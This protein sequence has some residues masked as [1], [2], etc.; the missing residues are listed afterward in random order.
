MFG[1]VA[2]QRHA[3]RDVLGTVVAGWDDVR[4]T[5]DEAGV[6]APTV[7]TGSV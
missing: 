6:H 3:C 5:V 7:A 4:V 2:A 1:R